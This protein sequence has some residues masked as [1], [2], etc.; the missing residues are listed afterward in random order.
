MH[1][2]VLNVAILRTMSAAG[3]YMAFTLSLAV[4]STVYTPLLT[5]RRQTFPRWQTFVIKNYSIKE[6]RGDTGPPGYKIWSCI[7]EWRDGCDTDLRM[8]GPRHWSS[9][10]GT[11]TTR[12]TRGTR[13]SRCRTS[14]LAS[15]PFVKYRVS[16]GKQL[17]SIAELSFL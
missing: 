16:G 4:P 15:L 11:G 14:S 1:G 8:C 5:T 17:W 3:R 12:R 6:V 9:G 13:T 7:S 10:T 2:G